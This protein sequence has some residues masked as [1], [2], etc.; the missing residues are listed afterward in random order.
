MP[1]AEKVRA[2]LAELERHN[3]FGAFVLAD[4]VTLSHGP[5]LIDAARAWL[6]EQDRKEANDAT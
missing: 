1:D 4:E 6:A 5:T 3:H 2:A